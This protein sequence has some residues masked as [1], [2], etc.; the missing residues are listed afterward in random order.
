MGEPDALSRRS[1]Q[2]KSGIDVKF[3][4]EGQLL[5]LEEDENNNEGKAEDIELKET[6]AWK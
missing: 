2:E 1:E 4:E 3:F 5:D 6:E